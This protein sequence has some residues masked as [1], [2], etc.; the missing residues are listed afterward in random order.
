MDP[1]VAAL[2]LAAPGLAPG[3]QAPPP[4]QPTTVREAAEGFEAIFLTFIL[5]GLR[6]T[7]PQADPKGTPFTRR[8]YED[9]LHQ[10][11]ATHLAKA[12]GLGLARMI[13]GSVSKAPGS[14][15]PRR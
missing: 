8:V 15:P 9:V 14:P 4:P 2:P 1:T 10:Y 6:Q 7:I 3:L 12:G 13:E 11:L 5:R